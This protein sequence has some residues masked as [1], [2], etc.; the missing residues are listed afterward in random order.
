MLKKCLIISTAND[1][2]RLIPESI[3]YISADGNYCN[4]MFTDNETRLLTHQLGI[5]EAMIHD[6]LGS[7]GLLFVRIG[8]GLIINRNYIYYI[9]IQNQKLIL[10]DNSRFSHTVSASRD[11]LKNLKDLVEKEVK[12]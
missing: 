8:R 3:V 2:V 5:V 4:V 10:S 1:L 6:Q 9:N 11:A 12:A 7:E